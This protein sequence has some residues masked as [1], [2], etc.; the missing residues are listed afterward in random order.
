MGNYF[1]IA[2]VLLFHPGQKDGQS[3][4]AFSIFP[5]AASMS[6]QQNDPKFMASV[7]CLMHEHRLNI[8]DFSA[9]DLMLINVL[10]KPLLFVNKYADVIELLEKR[11]TNFS[12]RPRS[13]FV[14]E[15]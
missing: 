2:R 10:G 9:G 6:G 3:L 4:E 1:P 5:M 13:I 12:S 8:F 7:S 15:L 11:S 14:R